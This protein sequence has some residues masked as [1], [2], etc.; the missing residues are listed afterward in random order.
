MNTPNTKYRSNQSVDRLIAFSISYQRENLLARGVGLEHLREFMLGIA[1][2]L[3]RQGASLAYGGSWA[4][5]EGNFTYDLLELIKAEQEDNSIQGPDTSFPIGSLYNH[6]AWPYYDS[7]TPEIEAQWVNCCR[8]IRVTQEEAGF[9]E[10]EILGPAGSDSD[11]NSDRIVFNRAYV[12]SAMRRIMSEGCDLSLPALGH[13]AFVP[14]VA[15]RIVIG[16]KVDGYAGMMPGFFEETLHALRRG[17]PLYILGGFG[18]GGEVLAKGLLADAGATVPELGFDHH[19]RETPDVACIN[20]LCGKFRKPAGFTPESL[21]DE[22]GSAIDNAAANFPRSLSNGLSEDEN[23]LL[24][25]T[26]DINEARRLVR[27][28]LNQNFNMSRLAE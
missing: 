25:T 24:L 4:Q 26:S 13:Q 21:F 28:G 27:M 16:G 6:V 20:E 19:R 22:L 12:L 17:I 14:G 9:R 11:S 8:I 23:R 18:G 10:D 7:I 3:L 2:P 5:M 15:A 1:R